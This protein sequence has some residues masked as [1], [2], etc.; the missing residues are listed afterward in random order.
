MRLRG[1]EA[2]RSQLLRVSV[3]PWPVSVAWW[4]QRA[5]VWGLRKAISATRRSKSVGSEPSV[6]FMIDCRDCTWL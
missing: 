1:I 3:P 5:P 6:G 4:C 2:R